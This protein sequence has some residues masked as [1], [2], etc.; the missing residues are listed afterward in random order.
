LSRPQRTS[1]R[2]VMT[3]RHPTGK[4]L[5]LSR[6]L[7]SLQGK[8]ILLPFFGNTWSYPRIL[9]RRRGVTRRHERWGRVRWTC[10]CRRTSD[11]RDG[12]PSRVVLI[13]RRWDQARGR[14]HGRR[15]LS[16]P[17]LRG[18]HEAAVKTIAQGMPDRSGLPVVTNSYAFYTCIRGCGCGLAPGIPCALPQGEGNR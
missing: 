18:E 1:R 12:R 10:W 11:G 5:L 7:S 4:S 3:P 8:N 15:R 6:S 2:R 14:I 9:H 17:V 13:S 16:S